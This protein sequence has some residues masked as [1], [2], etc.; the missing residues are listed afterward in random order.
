[1]VRRPVVGGRAVSQLVKQRALPLGL[2]ALGLRELSGDFADALPECLCGL[3]D[4]RAEPNSGA[5]FLQV[6]NLQL[7][8]CSN[9][10]LGVVRV[11]RINGGL[12]SDWLLLVCLLG[13][14]YF[15][16]RPR[17]LASSSISR[18]RSTGSIA[19]ILRAADLR[20]SSRS[21]ESFTDFIG[22][23]LLGE[24]H[25]AHAFG[26]RFG[27]VL[28]LLEQQHVR[29]A[30]R[31]HLALRDLVFGHD[32]PVLSAGLSGVFVCRRLGRSGFWCSGHRLNSGGRFNFRLR[33]SRR[34]RCNWLG[35]LA[36]DLEEV[37][38]AR[39]RTRI[40]DG[41][42]DCHLISA[43]S[44]LDGFAA[45]VVQQRLT[46]HEWR[47]GAIWVVDDLNINCGIRRAPCA[48]Q[49]AASRLRLGTP[50][51]FRRDTRALCRLAQCIVSKSSSIVS[52]LNACHRRTH[53]SWGICS[54]CVRLP[55]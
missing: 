29:P 51:P 55:L 47:H 45:V 3:V 10:S 54:Q 19:S 12:R 24:A 13:L 46:F 31:V 15:T 48:E 25:R 4:L 53:N 14:G 50:G 52:R 34:G 22:D 49:H 37:R 28:N 17:R 35:T 27:R 42:L 9:S 2:F 36:L 1:M 11:E 23:L 20:S 30:Q 16:F 38:L 7:C 18:L 26:V 40:A 32:R 5:N 43:G 41:L 21:G 6:R 8:N 39:H 33:R 44:D